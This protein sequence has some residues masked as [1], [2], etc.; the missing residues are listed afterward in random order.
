[1]T[2]VTTRTTNNHEPTQEGQDAWSETRA[3]ELAAEEGITL[4]PAPGT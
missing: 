1:M 4:T 3:L 2:T